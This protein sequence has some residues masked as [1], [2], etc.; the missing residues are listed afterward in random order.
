MNKRTRCSCTS[1]YKGYHWNVGGPQ[2]HDLHRMFDDHAKL[3]LDT[4]DPLAERQRI[5]G[6]PAP[7]DLDSL[8]RSS[9]LSVDAHRPATGLEMVEHL[10]EAHRHILRGLRVG[11]ELTTE[12]HDPGTADLLTQCLLVH[13]KLEWFLREL[14]EHRVEPFEGPSGNPVVVA[15]RGPIP[16][17]VA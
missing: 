14:L 15:Y 2:F 9:Q 1:R 8:R 5:L 3:V 11:I 12:V 16:P 7:Y 4:I 6:A 10:L 13:E 17:G